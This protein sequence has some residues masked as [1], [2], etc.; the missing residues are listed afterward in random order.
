MKLT[1]VCPELSGNG[2]TET[3]IDKA[4]NHLVKRH[5][6]KLVVTSIPANRLWLDVLDLNVEILQVTSSS[7]LSKLS[8]L[9][10]VLWQASNDETIVMLGANVI[11]LAAKIRQIRRRHWRLISWIHY[12]LINQDIFNPQNITYA[13]EHWAISTPI[14]NQLA[15]LGIEKGSIHLL[16]NPVT[17]YTGPLNHPLGDKVVRLVYVGQIMLHG[18]KNLQELLDGI[19]RYGNGVHLDLF[20]AKKDDNLVE[21]YA[22]EI[23]VLD[24]CTFHGW[25]TNLWKE[26]LEEVHP[27]ALVLTSKYEGL[28][29]VMI[30]A[31]AHGIPCFTADFSGYEDVIIP[32]KNGLVYHLGDLDDFTQTLERV[33]K[34]DFYSTEVQNTMCK[35]YDDNYYKRLKQLVD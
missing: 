15:D 28:P 5:Q 16:L 35:F 31:M 19:K 6:V 14:A 23:G 30:E 9:L 12:S 17:P 20:G 21:K 13:D 11:K 10:K 22:K 24:Q 34:T 26:V 1:F 8:L 4:L 32:S 29:M 18:Q 2:G 33:R 27:N 7:K 3:V 25:T